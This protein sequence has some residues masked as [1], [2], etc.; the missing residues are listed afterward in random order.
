LLCLRHLC[1]DAFS[2]LYDWRFQMTALSSSARFFALRLKPGDDIILELRKFVNANDL[3]A[4]AIVT[5]V[6]SL[7]SA[8]LRYANVSEWDRI[9]GHFEILSLVGTI[10]ANGEHV[11]ISLSDGTGKAI[12]AHFG[13]GSSVYT[14]AEIVLAELVDLEF[15]R[16]PCELSGWD[17]LTIS[18]RS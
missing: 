7:T 10:D 14:T 11:H 8:L 17:E 15:D 12:G 3:K 5:A 1:A 2:R 9:S 16:E 4:V 13:V 6:G 18:G